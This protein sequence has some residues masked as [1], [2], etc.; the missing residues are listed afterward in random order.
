M[1]DTKK[2]IAIT[3]TS[4]FIVICLVALVFVT[5]NDK[6]VA[7]DTAVKK[8]QEANSNEAQKLQEQLAELAQFSSTTLNQKTLKQQMSTLVSS[9][10][11]GMSSSTQGTVLEQLKSLKP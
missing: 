4:L 8:K 2:V 9:K 11:G 7:F 6:Q 1:Y 3:L 10:K 5:K